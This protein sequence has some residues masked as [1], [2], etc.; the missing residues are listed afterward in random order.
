MLEKSPKT[1]CAGQELWKRRFCWAEPEEQLGLGQALTRLGLVLSPAASPLPAVGLF[2]SGSVPHSRLS[3]KCWGQSVRG[4]FGWTLN[5][6]QQ[7]TFRS[8]FKDKGC[9]WS[10]GIL[11]LPSIPAVLPWLLTVRCVC[12]HVSP[13]LPILWKSALSF[14]SL[15]IISHFQPDPLLL[16]LC[17]PLPWL[18]PSAFIT[19]APCTAQKPPKIKTV[20]SYSN[21]IIW[22]TKTATLWW[23]K[24]WVLEDELG[25][26]SWEGASWLCSRVNWQ[27]FDRILIVIVAESA[28]CLRFGVFGFGVFWYFFKLV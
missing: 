23:I 21:L 13:L 9:L 25:I 16:P 3:W 27:I 6:L 18:L 17:P 10:A 4:L 28:F 14:P 12:H 5:C 1:E 22:I 26:W 11:V 15:F 19:W 20:L 8:P 2:V 7:A 24:L